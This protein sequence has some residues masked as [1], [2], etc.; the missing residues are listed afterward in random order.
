MSNLTNTIK[1]VMYLL[2]FLF[3]LILLVGAVVISFTML[4]LSSAIVITIGVVL[5]GSYIFS[6]VLDWLF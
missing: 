3:Y 6:V 1:I 2:F 4:P 5:F